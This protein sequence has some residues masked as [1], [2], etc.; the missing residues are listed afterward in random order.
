M[1]NV[2][3]LSDTYGPGGKSGQPESV[4][5]PFFILNMVPKIMTILKIMMMLTPVLDKFYIGLGLQNT[6]SY[7]NAESTTIGT[8][9]TIQEQNIIIIINGLIMYSFSSWQCAWI[10]ITS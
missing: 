2:I 7:G 4:I 3:E 9:C 10:S 5:T 8:I 6:T 1:K